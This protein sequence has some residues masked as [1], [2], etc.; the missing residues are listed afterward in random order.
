[1]RCEKC[2]FVPHSPEQTRAFQGGKCWTCWWSEVRIEDKMTLA[3]LLEDQEYVAAGPVVPPTYA[4][5]AALGLAAIELN[6]EGEAEVTYTSLGASCFVGKAALAR[7][8]AMGAGKGDA[9]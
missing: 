9:P 1:M 3:L 6:A 2:D 7:L 8:F 4:R 5:L